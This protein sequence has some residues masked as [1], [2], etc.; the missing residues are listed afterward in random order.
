MTEGLVDLVARVIA[1]RD[2][3]RDVARAASFAAELLE[4]E[5][6]EGLARCEPAAIEARL[7]ARGFRGGRAAGAALAAAFELGRRVA[8]E[9]AR[10]PPKIGSGADVAT[11]ATPRLAPLT[12]EELWMLALD[13][14]SQLRAARCIAK[15]GL[16]GLGARAA[17]PLRAALRA[18]ASAFVLVHNHP[19]GD[20]T[21]SREDI[22][23]TASVAAA[24]EAVGVPL[25]DHVVV[26]RGGFSSV[27][28][29]E[30][31]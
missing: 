30:D 14:R 7:V 1:R 21:P 5:G 15:G 12:H 2:D 18:D 27:P 25:L 17:D 23:F 24:A 10:A 11:W 6:I 9:A 20:S 8:I 26:A 3:P 31:A 16:H 29:P 19:S 22:A 4:H 28:L 13:G